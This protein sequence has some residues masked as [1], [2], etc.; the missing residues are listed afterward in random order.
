MMTVFRL[1]L[2]TTTMA[3]ILII[4]F[5]PNLNEAIVDLD[6]RLLPFGWAKILWRLKVRHPKTGRVLLFGLKKAY[7]H[8]LLG[9]VLLMR[10]L[11]MLR[12]SGKALGYEHV[13]LSWILEDNTGMRRLIESVGGR[14]TRPI[15]SI[16]R[17]W[18]DAI[19]PGDE[20]SREKWPTI[21]QTVWLALTLDEGGE[22]NE[23]EA[24]LS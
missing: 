12:Q 13:E 20:R 10:V 7:Q 19:W 11:E 22:C 24:L 8:S 4:F 15:A 18:V 17:A 2:M 1:P 23:P 16:G 5:L 9:S 21:L 6:G 14:N 3:F